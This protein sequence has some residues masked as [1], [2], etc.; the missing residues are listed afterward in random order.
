[1][2][3]LCFAVRMA[4]ISARGHFVQS[5]SVSQQ[6]GVEEGWDMKPGG[7]SL[8]ALKGFHRLSGL[9]LA[10]RCVLQVEFS[11]TLRLNVRSHV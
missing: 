5:L 2:C 11:R 7:D 10:R 6:D 9:H 3:D 4:L 8:T 1:M